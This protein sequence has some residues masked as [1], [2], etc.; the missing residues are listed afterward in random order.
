MSYDEIMSILDEDED[1][2]RRNFV[3]MNPYKKELVQ[4]RH[5]ELANK[6]FKSLEDLKKLNKQPFK[7]F[8]PGLRQKIAN[9]AKAGKTAGRLALRAGEGLN[10]QYDHT[11]RKIGAIKGILKS[12]EDDQSGNN[13]RKFTREEYDNYDLILSHLIDE[14]YADS[15][16]AAEAILESMSEEWMESILSEANLTA[17]LIKAISRT[18]PP[19]EGA[20]SSLRRKLMTA[21]IKREISKTKERDKKRRFSGRA[22]DPTIPMRP[23]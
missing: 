5:V 7:K 3:P 9:T 20:R 8:R 10:R 22:A 21:L 14:G 12:L 13:I 11:E 6:T 2:R 23:R 17:E 15:E 1:W 18:N 4:A 19:P 16:V